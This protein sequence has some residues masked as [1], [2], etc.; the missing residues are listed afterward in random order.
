M[1]IFKCNRCGK[2]VEESPVENFLH[3]NIVQGLH[4]DSPIS[5]DLCT[6][7]YDAFNEWIQSNNPCETCLYTKVALDEEPCKSC[8]HC[9]DSSYIPMNDDNDNSVW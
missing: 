9:Y 5:R 3:I 1:K 2:T 8:A 6:S 4:T 7:C